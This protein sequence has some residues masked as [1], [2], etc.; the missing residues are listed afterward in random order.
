MHYAMRRKSKLAFVRF[1]P[2]DGQ[3]NL[4]ASLFLSPPLSGR[5]ENTCN[6]DGFPSGKQRGAASC[7]PQYRLVRLVGDRIWAEND[8]MVGRTA[9][10]TAASEVQPPMANPLV[11]HVVLY[12]KKASSEGKWRAER[13]GSAGQREAVSGIPSAARE[14]WRR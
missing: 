7:P 2:G 1:A 5:K 14:G 9:G 12:G 4:L 8:A 3:I 6:K 13:E 10:Q 11:V